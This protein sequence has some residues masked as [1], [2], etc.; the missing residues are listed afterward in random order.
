MPGNN[1]KNIIRGNSGLFTPSVVRALKDPG[2]ESISLSLSS[3]ITT[4]DSAVDSTASFKYNIPETGLRSTQQINVDWSKFENHTFF[5]SAQV[6]LNVAFDKIQNGFPFDGTRKETEIYLD[7]LTGYEKYVYDSYPKNIGY[8]FLSGTKSGYEAGG[9]TYVTVIDQAGAQYTDSSTVTDGRNVLN[10]KTSPLSFEYWLYIP[11]ITNDNQVILDR[12]SGSFG[13]MIG[14]SSSLSTTYATS[15]LYIS[16]GSNTYSVPVIFNKGEW[17]HFAWTW[18]RTPGFYQVTA[19]LNGNYYAS[20]SMPLEIDT[21]NINSNLY[22]GSGSIFP[23]VNFIPTN[24]LSGA[25]DDLRIWSSVRSPEEINQYIKKTVYAQQD[26]KLYFKFN[27][28]SGS[29]SLIVIDGSS[30]SLHGRLSLAG[31]T[32]NV[33]NIATSSIAGSSPVIYESLQLSP[34]LFGNHPAVI[35]YRNSNAL[36]ASIYDE[37]NPNIITKLVP[38][39]YFYEGQEEIGLPTEQ[40][41]IVDGYQAGDDPRS[42][43]L[44]ATQ[45]LLLLLYT[46]AKFFDEM[47]LYTQAFSDLNFVDYNSTDTIPDQF[48]QQ[49]A[50]S[51]GIELPPL[52]TGSTIDQFI[53]GQNY[54]DTPD[55]NIFSLQYIQNQIW[56]RILINLRDIAQSKG[57]LHAVKSFIRAIGIDPDNNFRIREYGGPT[58]QNLGFL[59]DKRNEIAS[60]LN[61]VSGGLITSPYLSGTRIEPGYP[62]ISGAPSDGLYTSG[63]WTYEATY[64]HVPT[65]KYPRYQSLVRFMT[66]GSSFTTSGGLVANLIATSGNLAFPTLLTA[67][68]SAYVRPND[69]GS[70]PFLALHLTGVDI[71]DGDKWYISFGKQRNDDGLN[72]VV[73]SSYFLRAAKNSYGDIIFS[74]VTSSWFDETVGGGNNVWN[75]VDNSTN[76]SGSML[77]IGS[78][79]IESNTLFLNDPINVVNTARQTSFSGSVSFIRFW[80][81][82]IDTYEYLEHVRNYK[83]LGVQD[84]LTN[85]NFVTYKTGSFEK[86]RIDANTDQPV[87]QSNSSGEINIFDFSQNNL[88]LTGIN[89]PAVY[90]AIDPERYYYSYIS[91]KIDEASTTNKVRI[92]SFEQFANVEVTPW[93]QVTPVYEIPR[94]EEPTDSTKFTIDFSMVDALNQDIISIFA[95]LDELDNILGAP[96]LVFSPDYPGLE[97]LRSVYFNRLTNK[98]NFK[99]FFDF[100][101]WFDTNIGTFVAQLI[102]KKTKYFGTNFVIESHMLER[103]K[104]QYLFEEMYLGDSTR[105]SL[106]D[107]ILLQLFVASFVRY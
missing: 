7:S 1:I 71:F 104:F 78:G 84:P 66:T 95:T 17:N 96:E 33:R 30:N 86:L 94:S 73:S 12:H 24:T 89:F 90:Q 4:N 3:P 34:I 97:N 27:E 60:I 43:R 15:S 83:S 57:T 19:Y 61:F 54:S 20:S 44:G 75:A 18:N 25:I 10:F 29:N 85:F 47:K 6:K 41:A 93:A 46:W 74:Q 45:T 62:N 64:K 2:N 98:V 40:G 37:I 53:N 59:R 81:K 76:A 92:R 52:W 77:V 9:G 50:R 5:N 23:P 91:P 107:T 35:A 99:N 11:T 16:S 82:Y 65:I 31:Q 42:T 56:R 22:V 26:L 63:S 79:T 102:P 106:R 70:S 32:L 103:P 49:L 72:S 88:H 67:S 100:F 39:H 68:L 55:A 51:Q 36:S 13:Y 14:L 80:S 28:P 21:I 8:L 48:L 105:S 58:T 69:N 38:R 87:T 101:Q